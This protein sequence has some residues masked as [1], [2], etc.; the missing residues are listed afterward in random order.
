MPKSKIHSASILA[1]QKP[2]SECG[3]QQ[4]EKILLNLSIS[5]KKRKSEEELCRLPND[6]E[7]CQ[8]NDLRKIL[9]PQLAKHTNRDVDD[10]YLLRWLRSK[11]GRFDETADGVKKDLVFRKAWGLDKIANWTAP[12][13]LEKYCGYG[14]LGD[15]SGNPILMSLLGNM[16]VEGMLRS[17]QS[18]DYIKFS[19]AAIEKAPEMARIAFNSMTPFLSEATQKLIEIPSEE[20]W[21]MALSEYVDLDAWP[22]HWGGRMC[23][24]GDPKCPSKV[25]YGLGPVPDSYYVDQSTV[26][27]DYDQLTTVYAGDKHLIE[28]R[29]KANTRIR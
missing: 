3:S 24:N 10:G 26:M 7:I 2:P 22:V 16:D 18:K 20:D 11:E 6:V 28:L 8:L 13:I 9:A 17:V 25:R 4:E 29:V 27:T 15:R 23:E 1:E 5:P 12:E 19:L 21:K 14:F